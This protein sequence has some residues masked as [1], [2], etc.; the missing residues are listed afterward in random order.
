M[1]EGNDAMSYGWSWRRSRLLA[2]VCAFVVPPSLILAC[3]GTQTIP[4]GHGCPPCEE[5][6]GQIMRFTGPD[7]PEMHVDPPPPD[8]VLIHGYVRAAADSL[9]LGGA[10]VTIPGTGLG[11]L[12][13]QSGSYEIRVPE[14]LAK[15]IRF[16]LVGY[17]SEILPIEVGEEGIARIDVQLRPCP[18][19]L[20]HAP[21]YDLTP[22][23]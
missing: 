10:E 20:D 13:T 9:P 17:T 3:S 7:Y 8:T 12:T 4:L 11:L 23:G 14:S 16:Q 19:C 21:A 22:G 6:T 2:R 5:P 15:Q 1:S 18:I